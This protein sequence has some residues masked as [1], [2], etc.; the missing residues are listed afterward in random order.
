MQVEAKWVR[1]HLPVCHYFLGDFLYHR[2]R[3]V[4]DDGSRVTQSIHVQLFLPPLVVISSF[5]GM[6]ILENLGSNFSLY[7]FI[8]KCRVGSLRRLASCRECNG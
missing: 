7:E 2:E 1:I 5:L 8:I 4:S 6:F 3:W